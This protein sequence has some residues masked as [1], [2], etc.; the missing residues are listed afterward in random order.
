MKRQS[1]KIKHDFLFDSEDIEITIPRLNSDL[2]EKSELKLTDALNAKDEESFF[3]LIGDVS[4]VVII[5]DI[6][7]CL[8]P[9]SERYKQFI[10]RCVVQ[11][12]NSHNI[13]VYQ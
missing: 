5:D 12:L 9:T 11:K 4:N 13:N 8:N 7:K 2:C 6:G 3:E 10:I 1:Y